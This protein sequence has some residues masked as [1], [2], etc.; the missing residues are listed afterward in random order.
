VEGFIGGIGGGILGAV[1]IKLIFPL[2][3]QWLTIFIIGA[4]IPIVAFFGD[5]CESMIKRD[6]GVKDSSNLFP[7][8]G[9]FLDRIDSLLFVGVFVYY[10][11]VWIG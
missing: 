6:T 9:G 7:G 8:H 10:Y 4:I 11:A 2:T 5:I 1:I 3:F